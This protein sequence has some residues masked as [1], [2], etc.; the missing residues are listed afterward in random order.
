MNVKNNYK[1]LNKQVYNF[2][3]YKII[4]VRYK[5]RYKIMT[6]RNDQLYHLRQTEKISKENQDLYFKEILIPQKKHDKPDQILFSFF[7]KS[8][9]VGYGGLVHIN[10]NNSSAEVSFVMDTQLE[11][12]FFSEFWE[13]FLNLLEMVLKDLNI[14]NK[15]YTYAFD[16]RPR[17]YKVLEKKGFFFEKK[18]TYLKNNKIISVK[19]HKKYFNGR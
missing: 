13:V 17:I 9:F 6:W 2:N 11:K 16:L 1:V 14:L 19:I 12:N 4:P 3:E 15:I 18:E 8:I 10:W 5:D 7:H